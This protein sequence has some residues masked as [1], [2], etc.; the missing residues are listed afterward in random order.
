MI[1][2]EPLGTLLVTSDINKKKETILSIQRTKFSLNFKQAHKTTLDSHG[3]HKK[4]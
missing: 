2:K 4:I 3:N 1:C